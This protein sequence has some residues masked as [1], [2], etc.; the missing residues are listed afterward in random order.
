ML[1]ALKTH[2]EYFKSIEAWQKK[3]ELRKMDRPFKEGDKILLQE[4]DPETETYTGNEI[5]FR[6]SHIL[7]DAEKF[8]LKKGYCIIS[9]DP[10]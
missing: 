1:H 7:K 9:L 5:E 3:C 2:P 6:I 4:W 10:N 8:G